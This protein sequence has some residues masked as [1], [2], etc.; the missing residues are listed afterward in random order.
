MSR[1]NTQLIQIDEGDSNILV[2]LIADSENEQ[3]EFSTPLNSPSFDSPK[4]IQERLL[5]NSKSA[6]V[7]MSNAAAIGGIDNNNKD[8]N[9]TTDTHES[10]AIE[11]CLKDEGEEDSQERRRRVAFRD[12]LVSQFDDTNL[13]S[14]DPNETAQDMI[15]AYQRECMTMKI[16]PIQILLDQLKGIYDLSTPIDTIDLTGVKLENRTC[17]VLEA[18]L[19]RVH[20][21]TLKLERTNLEDEGIIAIAEMVEFYGCAS[22]LLLAHN[23]KLRPRAWLTIGRTLKKSP[24]LETIDVGYCA[25]DEQTLTLLLR[26][27]R[28]NCGLKVLKMEGNNLTGK[29]TFILMAAMK[30]NENLEELYLSR[31][32]L[33]PE[34]GQHLGNILRSNHTL[35]VLDVSDN[36]LQDSGIRYIS[37]GIAEQQEGLRILNVSTNNLTHEGIHHISAMLP[38]TKSLKEL[39]ISNNRFSDP[40]LFMLKLGVLANRSVEK[41]IL[42]GTKITCE[43]AIAL[44]EV[45]AESR[46]LTHVDLRE[47]EIRVAGLMALSLALR[48]NHHLLHL[49][50]PKTFKVEQR[51]RQLI[52]DILGEMEKYRSRNHKEKEEKEK[53]EAKR[54]HEATHASSLIT[55]EENSKL[56]T[57]N[58]SEDHKREEE[59]EEKEVDPSLVG[60][61]DNVYTE[62]TE[63]AM[64]KEDPFQKAPVMDN[65]TVTPSEMEKTANALVMYSSEGDDEC[66]SPS[67]E[68]DLDFPGSEQNLFLNEVVN[69]TGQTDNLDLIT[70]PAGSSNTSSVDIERRGLNNSQELLPDVVGISPSNTSEQNEERTLNIIP[71][72]SNHIPHSLPPDVTPHGTLPPDLAVESQH[73][74]DLLNPEGEVRDGPMDLTEGI[75]HSTNPDIAQ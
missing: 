17:E 1:E 75:P 39:N 54:V 36:N 9:D 26:A 58:N 2:D 25:L 16:K 37:A 45:L 19:S 23:N 21:T 7:G 35:R 68:D 4:E 22:R 50:T 27:V 14:H 44:A 56:T 6:V 34:D 47:N 11:N 70:S 72:P 43:G 42:A 10:E 28:A 24:F 20:A 63:A 18:V 3:E 55:N 57:G 29:G 65:E 48:M 49:E 59:E 52:K 62:E 64:M 51:D 31:N 74:I 69:P 53:E 38:C 13:W 71:P 66:F 60:S 67:P 5:S 30:F 12:D 33:A 40:G 61:L 32:H 73:T 15:T 41:L 46:Y 8:I